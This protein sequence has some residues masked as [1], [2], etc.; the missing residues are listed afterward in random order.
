MCVCACV[1][2]CV[3][4]CVCTHTPILLI[5]PPRK[6]N[7]VCVCVCVCVCIHIPPHVLCMYMIC[8]FKYAGQVLPNPLGLGYPFLCYVNKMI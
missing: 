5:E 1:C 3:C 7:C 8:V 6:P 2:V 4:V